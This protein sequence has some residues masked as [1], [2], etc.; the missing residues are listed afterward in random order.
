MPIRAVQ[1]AF[2]SERFNYTHARERYQSFN[3]AGRIS[4]AYEQRN[5]VSFHYV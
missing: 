3:F 2:L 1:R 4:L 5:I